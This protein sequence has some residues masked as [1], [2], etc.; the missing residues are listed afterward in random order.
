MHDHGGSCGRE[1]LLLLI[2]RIAG[3]HLGLSCLRRRIIRRLVRRIGDLLLLERLAALLLR[4]L[5]LEQLLVSRGGAQA[6]GDLLLLLL[7]VELVEKFEE[8]LVS[9]VLSVSAAAAGVGS[10]MIVN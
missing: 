6:W 1:L 3:R 9:R 4:L 8:F 7:L 5:L 2:D 10:R